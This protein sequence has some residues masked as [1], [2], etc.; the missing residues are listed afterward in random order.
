MAKPYKRKDSKFWW[1]APTI[2]GVQCPQSSGETDYDRA[3]T[4]LKILEGRI[5]SNAAITPKTDRGSFAALLELVRADFQIKGHLSLRHVASRIDLHLKPILGRIQA[6][7]ITVAV[8]QGYILERK[9]EDANVATI[10]RELAI[11]K[12]AFRLGM[13]A[14]EVS[15]MPYIEMLP[16]EKVQTGF[17]TEDGY[18]AVMRHAN[19]ILKDILVCC[20]YTGW[21]IDSIVNLE[22]SNVDLN[23]GLLALRQEQTK[24]KKATMFP[25]APF[26]ELHT[27]L[28][29]RKALTRETERRKSVVIPCVFHREG[30]PVKSIHSAWQWARK[31]AGLP[32]RKLHDFRRTA[33]RNLEDM[34]FT[35]TEIMSMVGMASRS[36]F[37]RYNIT[38]E[39]RILAKAKRLMDAAAIRK[40]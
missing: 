16:G 35:E 13:R 29:R 40:T 39:E 15:G 1:I 24:N 7:R 10:N 26:P 31:K 14:G 22:W 19:P 38:D 30:Q 18:R 27:M 34:G 33:V 2:N 36:I 12:R 17:F 25:L 9:R 6:G 8:I 20:Y 37:I 5:A 28:E 23:R 11:M 3:L 32:G 21:R 4:K